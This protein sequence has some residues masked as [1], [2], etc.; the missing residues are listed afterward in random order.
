MP[1][2]NIAFD[3]IPATI[4]KPGIYTEF[5]T[6]MAVNTLPANLYRVVIIG[7]RL[8]AGSVAANTPVD[9]FS[10]EDAAVYFGRGSIAHL[11]VRAAIKANRYL[12]LQ[13]IALDDAPA[14]VVAS[15]SVTITGTATTSGALRLLINKQPVD[16]AIASG[17]TA[18]TIA[19]ALNAQLALQP[20]LPVVAMVVAGVVTLTAKHK[21]ALGNSIK[22]A[23]VVQVTGITAVVAAMA[24]GLNDPDITPALAAIYTA[25][26]NIL[27]CTYNDT[28]N[29]TALRTH[30]NAVSG[31][32][33]K[34]RVRA[35]VAHTGTYAQSTTLAASINHGRILEVLNPNARESVYEVA[36]VM[37]AIAASEED[38]ARPL[39]GLELVGLTPPPMTNW[40]SEAQIEAALYN[41]VTPVRVGSGNVVQIVRAIT[42]YTL[43]ANGV[44][45]I[46]ML[47][48]TTIGTLDYVAK[49]VEEVVGLRFPRDKKSLR[50]KARLFD[51]IFNVLLKLEELEIIEG[52][53]KADLLI[54]DDLVD[55][56]RYDVRIRINVV[57]G[58][59]VIA[60]RLD[61]IL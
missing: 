49:A 6:K 53:S 41:G 5:N 33:E 29:L 18:G 37:G 13:A 40:L 55:P 26:H 43:N 60:Q 4:R 50:T 2:A 36:A 17:D 42:T 7:Q 21:G 45:D 8:A 47:D 19:A 20:D 25:G 23:T 51:A 16:I 61:L 52:V 3:S 58:M 9:V 44:P 34:R 22:L 12:S 56:S 39:N 10:D 27:I 1:S 46:S 15:G 11:A 57:N 54:E 31:P 30:V 14:G 48:W 24:G 32:Q 35:V 59:H 38:P 28:A